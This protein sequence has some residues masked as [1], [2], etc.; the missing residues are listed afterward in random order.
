MDIG[1]IGYE[2]GLPILDISGL[3]DRE[4]ARASGGFLHKRYPAGRLLARAPRFFV[5]VDGFPID[6]GILRDP[7][8]VAAYRLVLERN[9]RFNWTPPDSYVLHVYE[10]REAA[11]SDPLTSR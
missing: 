2:T 11:A 10:R 1:R 6:E 4:I 3:T 5:L 8:F 7:V 9:H